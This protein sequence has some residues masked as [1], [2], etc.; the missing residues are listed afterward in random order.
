MSYVTG[1][2]V[3]FH[4]FCNVFDSFYS[5]FHIWISGKWG[6]EVDRHRTWLPGNFRNINIFCKNIFV[7]FIPGWSFHCREKHDVWDCVNKDLKRRREKTV[8]GQQGCVTDAAVSWTKA[9]L[10]SPRRFPRWIGYKFPLG[11][12]TQ[13]LLS[14][15]CPEADGVTCWPVT[16]FLETISPYHIVNIY[17]R[18]GGVWQPGADPQLAWADRASYLI[19]NILLKNWAWRMD[20][21]GSLL[22]TYIWLCYYKC[23][24]HMHIRVYG[25]FLWSNRGLLPE[26]F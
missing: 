18:S 8:A 1:F 23:L 3:C 6:V 12:I 22:A 25:N 16:H 26:Q 5:I 19:W 21:E 7:L 15:S 13:R 4:S 14:A 9:S 11:L 20:Y 2:L 24:L 10:P 17:S